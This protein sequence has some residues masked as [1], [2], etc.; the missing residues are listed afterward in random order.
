M[1]ISSVRKS[2]LICVFAA[3]TLAVGCGVDGNYADSDG[4]AKMELKDGKAKINIGGILMEGT[5]TVEGN[6]LVIRST[7]GGPQSYT[8]TIDSDGSLEP[9]AGTGFPKL[10]KTK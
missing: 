8:F 7:E 2:L 6:K 4:A 3:V 10:L 1:N 5:Y 9:P